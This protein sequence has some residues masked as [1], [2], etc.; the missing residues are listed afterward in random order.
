MKSVE[1]QEWLEE[2]VTYVSSD[3]SGQAIDNTIKWSLPGMSQGESKRVCVTVSPQ[4]EG[5]FSACTT[6][7]AEPIICI[8]FLAG[9][10]R[11]A[12]GKSGPPQTELGETVTWDV[13]VTNE[14]TA[15]A[16]NVEV[17]DT[18]P[19]GFSAVS[20]TSQQ[21]G[22]L[23]PGQS[24]DFQ[25]SAKANQ[26]GAF[27]N[28]A[29]ATFAKGLEAVYD[30]APIVVIQSK[31]SID[32]TGPEKE[33]VYTGADYQIVVINIGETTLQ[34]LRV[35]E[36]LPADAKVISPG[37][38]TLKRD[39]I[40]WTIPSLA[41]GE[42]RSFDFQ[43][44]SNSPG[45]RTD[46]ARVVTQR[47]LKESDSVETE[48]LAVPAVQTSIVDNKDPIRVGEETTYTVKI[49][50]QGD[51]EPVGADIKVTLSS[52][53]EPVSTSGTTQGQI[54][55]NTVTFPQATIQP[56]RDLILKIVTRANEAGPGGAQLEF[57]T[58]FLTKPTI[59]EEP[60]N[61]Y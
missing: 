32:K 53:L 2:N 31:I 1:L 17:T 6:F 35:T 50:N 25:V 37:I 26:L 18:L 55:G 40:V 14:G 24:K 59:S 34:D 43:I 8:P 52:N 39:E 47:G 58:S 22:N 21:L 57:N 30:T 46:I 4:V 29:Q 61:V 28:L 36:I 60:T 10:P 51:F 41:A 48:W 42:S 16:K 23:T 56:K 12:I 9:S 20:E 19:S 27:E 5:T 45:K 38:G 54:S 7:S 44:T 11:L 15:E 33:Y 13:V 3:P 49:I